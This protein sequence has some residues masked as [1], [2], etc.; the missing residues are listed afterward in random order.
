MTTLG[1][2]ILLGRNSFST[3]NHTD[4]GKTSWHGTEGLYSWSTPVLQGSSIDLPSRDED[5][6]MHKIIIMLETKI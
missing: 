1:G 4:V 3:E 6:K 5:I 2:L